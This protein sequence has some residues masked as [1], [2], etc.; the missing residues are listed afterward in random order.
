MN[1]AT[2]RD[3]ISA[4]AAGLILAAIM[5]GSVLLRLPAFH[6][7]TGAGD[8]P[9]FSFHPDVGQFITGAQD[10]K[11]PNP[12]GY[13]EGLVTHLY[14]LHKLL[15]PLTG[16]GYMQILHG[17]TIF[18]AAMIALLT[19]VTARTWNMSRATALLAA[20]LWSIAPGAVVQSNFG[21]ADLTAVFY[22]YATLLVGGQY[23]RTGKSIWFVIL[24]ALVGMAVAVKFF[25][26][27][28]APLFLVLAIQRR[29]QMATSVLAA[30]F[31]VPGSFEMLSFFR[32][33]PWDLH[34]LY[35]ALRDDN[36]FI[37]STG[38]LAQLRAYSWRLVS[39][40]GIP[41]A[42]L[43]AIGVVGWLPSLRRSVPAIVK[44]AFS[45]D[46]RSLVTPATL[47]IA[48]LSLH[49]FLLLMA[50]AQA[51]RH[52]LVFLPVVCIAAS[53]T[54]LRLLDAGRVPVP[55]RWSIV[56][57]IVGFQLYDGIAIESIFTHDIRNDV[58]A[59]TDKQIADG[60]HVTAM[61]VYS[62]VRGSTYDQ[63]QNPLEL[64]KDSYL[65]TCDLEYDRYLGQGSVEG[66]FHAV[67][68]ESRMEFYRHILKDGQS[69]FGIVQEFVAQPQGIELRLIERDKM[70][71]LDAIVPRRCFALGRDNQLPQ[72][73]QRRIRAE[74]ATIRNGNG[75]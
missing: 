53:Y 75:W 14:V 72:D 26:P 11:A 43:L 57:V 61:M 51:V 74:L 38:P 50:G 40:V 27:L 48:A 16:A 47:F 34:H 45:R 7:L 59:W 23:L 42:L 20:G 62:G 31:I 71:Q 70:A 68:G 41:M 30:F 25:I 32:Y 33:T 60:K 1:D 4:R 56:V 28:F 9:D 18:Y 66:I 46:W 69:E 65:V 52:L 63:D 64:G 8:S 36:V 3:T 39:A 21:T 5:V 44:R 15:A 55:V 73:E 19:Y 67:G 24:C 54:L 13:P 49:A 37:G 35:W 17:I 12:V 29:E 22:F 2:P 10:I 6:W 58:A